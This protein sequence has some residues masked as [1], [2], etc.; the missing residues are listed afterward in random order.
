MT[1]LALLIDLQRCT[2][3]RSCEAACKLENRLGTDVFRT[4]VLWLEDDTGPTPR[5]EFVK[6]VCQQCERPACVRACPV[7]PKVL[8]KRDTDG[9][10][11]FD[12]SRCTGCQECV[13][14][15]PYHAISFDY[16]HQ[17]IEKCTLCHERRDQG[18]EPACVSVCP[19]RALS[20]GPVE[21][22]RTRADLQERAIRDVDHFGLRPS[23]VYLEG[24]P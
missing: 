15:C 16:E 8:H 5:L 6:A 9:I 1:Q 14:A 17:H 23:T 3:C 21:E 10:V 2:G 7:V 12:T 19:G 22:L 24:Q 20:F 13:K 18:L 4:R 11:V